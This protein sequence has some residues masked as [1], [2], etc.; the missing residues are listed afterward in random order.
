MYKVYGPG[1]A[2]AILAAAAY[3]ARRCELTA[4]H[5][6]DA[7]ASLGEDAFMSQVNTTLRVTRPALQART[8]GQGRPRRRPRRRPPFASYSLRPDPWR[9]LKSHRL[10]PPH[11]PSH[12]P[13]GADRPAGAAGPPAHPGLNHHRQLQ[14][15]RCGLPP[16]AVG[17]AADA[18]PARAGL[19]P[20]AVGAAANAAPA[21]CL[22]ARAPQPACQHDPPLDACFPRPHHP[23]AV[24]A[25]A[26]DA[27]IKHAVGC[28]LAAPERA[29]ARALLE[30]PAVDSRAFLDLAH[31]ETVTG[32]AFA[33]AT[34]QLERIALNAVNLEALARALPPAG[35]A[36]TT[37]CRIA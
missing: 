31:A 2:P 19:P 30:T 13:G 37:G 32:G 9:D 7:A 8:A 6:R 27:E 25:G 1:P 20:R 17:A 4:F 24:E 5:T 33:A 18:A 3:K 35:A 28:A 23:A 16:R 36:G 12:H 22:R 29:A 15:G 21:G 11:S 14:R 10:H 26:D 34:K